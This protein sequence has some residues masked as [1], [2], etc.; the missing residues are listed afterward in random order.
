MQ[1]GSSNTVAMAETLLGSHQETTGPQPADPKRQ[2]AHMQNL[3]LDPGAPGFPGVVNPDLASLV[4]GWTRWTGQ[5]GHA[6]ISGKPFAGTFCTYM[7]PNTPV[8]DLWGKGA[9][10]FAARSNHPGGANA[11]LGDG[12]V[13]FVSETIDLLTWRAVGTCSGGEVVG[14]F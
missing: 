10:F 12:S 1:D 13:R 8:P 2:M 5:R 11:L 14:A 6:W 7:P 4:A 9:G 3:T